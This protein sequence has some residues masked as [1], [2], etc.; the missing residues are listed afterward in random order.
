MIKDPVFAEFDLKGRL[1]VCEFQSYMMN[2]DGTGEHDAISRVQV[3][4]DTDGDG[5]MDK[6]ITFLDKIVN[7]RSLSIVKGGA[8]VSLGSGKLIFAED[9]DGDLVADKR[10]PL[11]DFATAAPN[12]I[13]HAENGLHFAIDNWM[14]NSKSQ[15][16][17]QW[18]DGKIIEDHQVSRPV[19][20][21]FGR[22]R[23]ALLQ[24]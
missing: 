24:L 19:G 10:T 8:L 9:T 15:R 14:Y 2:A 16:R 20:H 18:R 21:G 3:L 22:L 7:P 13:E 12:N 6:A 5:R 1:W 11:I 4:E 23:P 17:L